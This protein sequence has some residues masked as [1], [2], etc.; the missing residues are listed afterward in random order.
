MQLQ[1]LLKN[2]PEQGHQLFAN[3]ACMFTV[4][5]PRA[6]R[7]D[8]QCLSP[9]QQTVPMVATEG[10]WHADVHEVS[11][12]TLYQVVLDGRLTRP[13]PAS[14]LLPYGVHG[15][16]RVVDHEAFVWK[17]RTF[18]P[19]ALRDSILYELHI[20]TFTPEG[21]FAAAVGRLDDLAALGVT[22]V[23]VMPLSQYPGGRNWGYDGVQPYSVQNTYGGPEGFKAFVDACHE[24]GLA[25][26]LDVVFNHLG[27]EGNYLRDFGPYFT[28]RHKTPWGE[29]VNLDGPYS[30]HVRAYFLHSL[31]HWL[32]RYHV[33]GFRLD[34]TH[35]YHDKRPDPFLGQIGE[36]ARTYLTEA[37][38][39]PIIL[40]EDDLND[41]RISAPP[42]RGGMGLTGQYSEDFHHC[43]H[44]LLTGERQ[45]YYAD[46][47]SACRLAK[48][49]R[50]GF[51]YTGEYAVSRQRSHGAGAV[52]L[53]PE[54]IVACIQNHDQTGN[55]AQ[56]ERLDALIGFEARKVA[57]GLLLLAP[58]TPL[59]FMGEEYGEDNPFLYFVSHED[60][61]LTEAVRR[62]RMLE[63]AGF[64]PDG[65]Q[66]P[67]PA[68]KETFARSVLDWGKRAHGRHHILLE[69]YASLVRLRR[70]HVRPPGGHIVRPKVHLF[71]RS[72]LLAL[73]YASHGGTHM[74]F[75]LSPD[76]LAVDFDRLGVSGA[77]LLDS[78]EAVWGGRGPSLPG[79]PEG[80]PPMASWSFSVYAGV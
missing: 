43:V 78:S 54:K 14:H 3:R 31:S 66:P 59:L 47:G 20:G 63:F 4:W 27:P 35:A 67:D 74:L 10:Y 80:T 75:N 50:T 1:G 77:K 45:S 29:A 68:G 9:V 2:H 64:D 46:F 16:S 32:R 28:D 41:T 70:D 33:D 57:A 11:A 34:A 13:D 42:A 58:Y 71:K 23:Q 19:V 44:A 65:P 52:R 25:V 8:I 18:T 17:C 79:S 5:A 72:R 76:E 6:T 7:V 30:D 60:H 22:A 62:G 37:G 53:P 38:V 55:R 36:L 73:R 61:A 15:P 26:I 21:T 24:R 56:G 51:A 40:A 12:E 69:L 49:M 39:Q 48:A